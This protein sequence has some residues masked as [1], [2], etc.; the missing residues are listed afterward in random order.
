M[1]KLENENILK[2]IFDNLK[3]SNLKQLYTILKNK[4]ANK[5]LLKYLTFE[6][7]FKSINSSKLLFQASE[8][9]DISSAAILPDGNLI[10]SGLNKLTIW[11]MKTYECIK[12]IHDDFSLMILLPSDNIVS[13]SFHGCI[14]FWDAKEDYK[15]F[16]EMQI[17]FGIYKLFLLTCGKLIYCIQD[18]QEE[19]KD[20]IDYSPNS[21][22]TLDYINGFEV[23]ELKDYKSTVSALANLLENK[24]AIAVWRIISICIINSDGIKL[25][26][27]LRGH[28]DDIN[29][30]LFVEKE[31]MLISGAH[32]N[33][34]RL[35]NLNNYCCIKT[36]NVGVS[37]G[38]FLK[39]PGEYFAFSNG[40]VMNI[41]SLNSFQC[42]NSVETVEGGI[43][44]MFLLKDYRIIAITYKSEY[45]EINDYCYT[46]P[47]N[48]V[49]F[50][51]I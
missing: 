4:T 12:T 42:I 25:C 7:T 27:S 22:Y 46:C 13:S 29:D 2:L 1:A 16:K 6:N 47:T 15:C 43:W 35:W 18:Y 51:N 44:G 8:W 24:L 34:I 21:I 39:L 20:E 36:I 10:L 37:V 28:N 5:I 41:F 14:K 31:N 45:L 3:F 19:R 48:L 30:L 49:V 38:Y 26:V 40:G 11:D 33:T 50:E 23:K 17:H 9:N 32:D